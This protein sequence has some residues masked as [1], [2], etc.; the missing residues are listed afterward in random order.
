M[1]KSALALTSVGIGA[2]ILYVVG[3]GRSKSRLRESAK[4][5]AQ[6]AN[7]GK[8]EAETAS[9]ERQ[10]GQESKAPSMAPLK[11]GE[12]ESADFELD[13][14]GTNQQAALQLLDKIKAEAFDSS[15]DKLAL[16]LGRPVEEIS[17]W[18]MGEQSI[19]SDLLMKARA[20]A[21]ERGVNI[22]SH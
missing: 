4:S 20:L 14:R 17:A 2:G 6:G 16:A 22:E 9:T 11:D 12:A 21:L 7:T 8:S 10:T 18:S 1:R 3:K 19:D 13:D 5:N 15:D